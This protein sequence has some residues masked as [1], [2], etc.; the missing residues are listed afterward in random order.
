MT[1]CTYCGED[2]DRFET[3]VETEV[4]IEDR[5]Y[6]IKPSFCSWQH[7]AAWFN[8]P[9][10]DVEAWTRTGPA[11]KAPV[12]GGVMTWLILAFLVTILLAAVITLSVTLG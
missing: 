9:P 4:F 8:Q 3:V 12:D 5:G 11:P 6:V 1:A 10:P 7:T 2:R